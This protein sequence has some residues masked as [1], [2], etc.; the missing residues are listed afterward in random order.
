MKQR[1]TM[2]GRILRS[3]AVSTIS[4]ALVMLV[5]GGIGY[6]MASLWQQAEAVRSSVTM[7]V[8]LDDKVS[9]ER[10]D[11]LAATIAQRA[12]VKEVRYVSKEEKMADEEFRRAFDVD[13]EAMLGENPLPNSLDVILL[14]SSE[15]SEALQTFID[16]CK[17]LEGVTHISYPAQVLDE[18]H[19]VMGTMQLLMSIFGGAMLLIS[20]VLLRNTV[21]L[22][23]FSRRETID[24]MKAVGATKW[25]IMRPFL[26]RAALQGAVAGLLASLALGGT[27][28]AI[29]RNVAELG[30]LSQ[31]ELLAIIAA[32]I[33]L[34]AVVV[35]VL[36]TLFA[37]NKFVNMSS[38]KIHLY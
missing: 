29:D 18:V 7:I 25:F 30:I 3:T 36:F 21:R 1:K 14:A 11:T 12:M 32:A 38:N 10:A 37:V 19:S 20:L 16:E 24:T 28:Y 34:S 23:I 5:L 31:V 17:A 9:V 4:I 33:T 26:G 6:I 15:D 13:I 8:E 35:V 27:L 2:R 22:N